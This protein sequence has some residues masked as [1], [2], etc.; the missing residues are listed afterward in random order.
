MISHLVCIV[1]MMMDSPSKAN[2]RITITLTPFMF[3]SPAFQSILNLA[4]RG[5]K[6][7]CTQLPALIQ[8]SSVFTSECNCHLWKKNLHQMRESGWNSLKKP[9]FSRLKNKFASEWLWGWSDG[10]KCARWDLFW[11]KQEKGSHTHLACSKDRGSL[12]GR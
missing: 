6:E 4:A 3:Q 7:K 11:G 5:K 10:H 2:A 12:W 1:N 8:S 9:F